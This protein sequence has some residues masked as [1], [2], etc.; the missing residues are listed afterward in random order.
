[1][2][3][4]KMHVCLHSFLVFLASCFFSMVCLSVRLLRRLAKAMAAT[5]QASTRNIS[6]FFIVVVFDIKITTISGPDFLNLKK[7]QFNYAESK[8]LMTL[9]P[10]AL[11]LQPLWW[12]LALRRECLRSS[13]GRATDS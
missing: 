7:W 12:F 8:S 5:R 2:A 3:Q 13:V 10:E 6:V 4:L 11:Y 9:G 1:L